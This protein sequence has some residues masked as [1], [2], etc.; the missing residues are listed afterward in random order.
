MP[1]PPKPSLGL[2]R[3]REKESGN[4][5]PLVRCGGWGWS[6]LPTPGAGVDEFPMHPWTLAWSSGALP[7]TPSPSLRVV[8]TRFQRRCSWRHLP[9][10]VLVLALVLGSGWWQAGPCW[11]QSL[12]VVIPQAGSGSVPQLLRTRCRRGPKKWSHEQ[13][14]LALW[15]GSGGRGRQQ[16]R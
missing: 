2:G 16:T 8:G 13:A 10:L 14:E 11:W 9:S 15:G 7:V 1:P 12:P 3:S 5:P 6:L 4:S